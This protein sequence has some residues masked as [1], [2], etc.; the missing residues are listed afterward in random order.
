MLSFNARSI[1]N[2]FSDLEELVA[3]EKFDLIAITESWL[4]TKDRDFL[5]EY[6]LPGYSIS[7]CGRENRAWGGVILYINNNFY[8]CAI[9]TE[10]IN[11]VDL[12]FVEL[13]SHNNK[14]I[15]C[16]IYRPPGQSPETDNKLFNIVIETCRYF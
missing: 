3:T 1:R 12:N 8:Q 2:K 4:N 15:V 16:L 11:N 13:R 5:T 10:N 6:N 7:S 9:K 14:I